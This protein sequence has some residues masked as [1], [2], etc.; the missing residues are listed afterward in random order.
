MFKIYLGKHFDQIFEKRFIEIKREFAYDQQKELAM[1]NHRA[2]GWGALQK[3]KVMENATFGPVFDREGI[4]TSSISFL[5][6]WKTEIIAKI[7]S[8]K[9]AISSSVFKSN[10]FIFKL[11]DAYDKQFCKME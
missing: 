4:F 10:A 9:F 11:Q 8:R 2:I 6:F 1:E 7:G 3:K 5:F